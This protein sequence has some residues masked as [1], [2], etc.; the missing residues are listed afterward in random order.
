MF[1]WYCQ[2]RLATA[3]SDLERRMGRE[4]LSATG[5]LPLRITARQRRVYRATRINNYAKYGRPENP[6]DPHSRIIPANQRRR[7]AAD[8][9]DDHFSPGPD[10]E[11]DSDET[12][13]QT[14]QRRSE[15]LARET[16]VYDDDDDDPDDDSDDNL[17]LEL[18][19]RKRKEKDEQT[20]K[21]LEAERKRRMAVERGAR[22]EDVTLDDVTDG[23]NPRSFGFLL[24]GGYSRF[25]RHPASSSGNF[26][27]IHNSNCH[28]GFFF[29]FCF[30]FFRCF[31]PRYA[32]PYSEI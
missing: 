9:A 13:Q 6:Q 17:S 32:R 30:V 5:D 24:A 26:C 8:L 22:Y 4:L 31:F 20:K 28:C 23:R 7:L 21:D 25:D 2:A 11:S 1:F 10:D 27:C 18:R 19:R 14:E 29:R 15:C 16:H 3:P 12:P